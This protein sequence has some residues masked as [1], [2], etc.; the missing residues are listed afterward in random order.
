MTYYAQTMPGVEEIAWLEIRQRLKGAHF[1]RYLFAKEQNG[2]VV[3]DY[4]GPAADLLRLRTTEDVFMQIA[5]HDDLTRLKRDLKQLYELV[6]TGETV[7]RAANDY[8]R[9]RRF[10]APPTYRVISRQ[11]GRFEYTRKDLTATI[12]R[13][14]KVRYPRWTPVADDSQVEFWANLLGSQFL[15]GARLSDRTMRHRFER[16]VEL[17]AALRPSVAAAMV[18]LT[19]PQPGEVFLDPMAG[20]GTILYERMQAGPFGKVLGGDI[21]QERVDAA[22]KNVRGSRKKPTAGDPPVDIQKW[23]ARKLPLDD[24]SVDKVA[25]NLP[26][27]KQLRAAEQPAKLYPPVLAE[28][29]R[30]VRPGG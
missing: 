29:Q 6:A 27:G 7:G 19:E 15:L 18:F 12:W 4:P 8:L 14:L 22:R 30:V 2:I 9:V 23:D 5:Y 1:V 26:F 10:S 21:E 11:Y 16:K 24:A 25:T 17:P 28:L 3:F 13:A 20:S